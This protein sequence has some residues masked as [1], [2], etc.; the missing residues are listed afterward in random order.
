MRRALSSSATWRMERTVPGTDRVFKSS[1]DVACDL[2]GGGGIVWR[3]LAPFASTVSMR[4]DAMVFEDEDGRREKPAG[5]MPH[6]EDIRKATDAFAAGDDGAFARVFDT[7]ASA[8][9]G[10]RWKIV[11]KPRGSAAGKLVEYAAIEGAGLPETVVIRAANGGESRI[12]F[13]RKEGDAGKKE[14]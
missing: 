6:Y 4:K 1:G 8:L 2:G 14:R 11:M 10:G 13:K 7:S 9:P 5:D 12:S 3:T